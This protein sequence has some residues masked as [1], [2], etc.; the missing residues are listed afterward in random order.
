MIAEFIRMLSPGS[1]RIS[2]T[3]PPQRSSTRGWRADNLPMGQMITCRSPDHEPVMVRLEP[4]NPQS[5]YP[6][7]H[8]AAAFHPSPLT[9]LSALPHLHVEYQ[10]T[11]AVVSLPDG[12]LIEGSLPA[13]KLRLLQAWV[14]SWTNALGEP[15]LISARVGLLRLH[16]AGLIA[17]RHVGQRQWARADARTD[18]V[19]ASDHSGRAGGCALGCAP[20]RGAREGGLAVMERPH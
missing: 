18:A 11:E 9:F 8:P 10:G 2:S 5:R 19:A 3:S 20:E 1:A 7:E 4:P 12:E 14:T 15:K 6:T 17:R 13:K 16:R